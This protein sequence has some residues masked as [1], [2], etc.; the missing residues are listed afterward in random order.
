VPNGGNQ[1]RRLAPWAGAVLLLSGLLVFGFVKDAISFEIPT[2]VVGPPLCEGL[3]SKGRQF[4]ADTRDVN[5]TAIT[6]SNAG[7]GVVYR[8]AANTDSDFD[9]LG[10]LLPPNCQVGFEGFCI[11]EAREDLSGSK[12][13]PLDQQWFILPNNRGYVHGGV[14]Q[15]LPPGTIGQEP[16]ECNGGH[17]QPTNL[18]YIGGPPTRLKGPTRVELQA[19]NAATVAAAIYANDVDGSSAWHP[20]AIDIDSSDGFIL[21]LDPSGIAPQEGATL[22]LVAC[23]AGNVPGRATTATAVRVGGSVGGR[24]RTP[25]PPNLIQGSSVACKQ[26]AGGS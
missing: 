6:E 4:E 16:Q 1:W 9:V 8:K 24:Q 13:T 23:W 10:R 21:T 12:N 3:D 14:V 7:K 17:D 19:E 5:F 15:E 2:R 26:V 20:L 22:L 25:A 18:V 11:G